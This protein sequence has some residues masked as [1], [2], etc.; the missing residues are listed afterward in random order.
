VD[1]VTALIVNKNLDG[2]AM[3]AV[4]TADNIAN[5]NAPGFRPSRISFEA[6]LRGA[7]AQGLGAVARVQPQLV[8]DAAPGGDGPRLD[9]ELAT[10]AETSMRYAALINL[11]GRQMQISHLAIRGGQ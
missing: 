6:A 2:L 8:S 9:Q 4:V 3:R 7:A 10:A 5:A 11:L 1:P